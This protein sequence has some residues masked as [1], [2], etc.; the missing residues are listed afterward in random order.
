MADI[1]HILNE[2]GFEFHNS[3]EVFTVYIC[4]LCSDVHTYQLFSIALSNTPIYPLGLFTS[5]FL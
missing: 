2:A 1:L 5:H 3:V 4:K